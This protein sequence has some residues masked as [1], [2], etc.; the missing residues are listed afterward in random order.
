MTDFI[1]SRRRYPGRVRHGTSFVNAGRIEAVN[2]Y[3]GNRVQI[4]TVEGVVLATLTSLA[5]NAPNFSVQDV[6][7]TVSQYG[8]TPHLVLTFHGFEIGSND[9]EEIEVSTDYPV[10]P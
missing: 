8:G 3:D 7:A 4:E 9:Q 6:E 5:N 1:A 10:T 2:I